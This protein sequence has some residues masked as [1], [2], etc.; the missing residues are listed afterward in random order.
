MKE[1]CM[2][3]QGYAPSE[4]IK[5][6]VLMV[7]MENYVNKSAMFLK[8]GKLA[9]GIK[10]T[11]DSMEIVEHLKDIGYVLFHTRKN[12]DQHLFAI[13]GTCAIKSTDDLEK[14]RY[15]NVM[16]TAIYVSVNIDCSIE[17]DSSHIRSINIAF[18]PV[19][20]YD[21]QFATIGSLSIE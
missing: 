1:F 16:T 19:T 7:M 9:I 20:K 8:N 5:N 14:D 18:T 6:G 4:N 2:I 17:L 13:K 15:R 21:A 11:K 3:A 12:T 10:Y